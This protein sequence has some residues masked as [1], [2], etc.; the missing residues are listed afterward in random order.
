MKNFFN[1]FFFHLKMNKFIIVIY[2]FFIIIEILLLLLLSF[3]DWLNFKLSILPYL[4][5][6]IFFY[7]FKLKYIWLEF[8]IKI[9]ISITLIEIFLIPI[10][11]RY[12][13]YYTYIILYLGEFFSIY[14]KKNIINK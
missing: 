3:D 2:L 1:N 14:N 7:F 12:F 11:F 13:I 8:I 5:P 4:A 9:I 10:G 6:F